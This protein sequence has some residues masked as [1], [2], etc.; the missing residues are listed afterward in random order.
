M[1]KRKAIIGIL[2][3][4]VV[5]SVTYAAIGSTVQVKVK[6]GQNCEIEERCADMMYVDCGAATDGPAYFLDGA[7]EVIGT[8]G[9]LCMMGNCSGAPEEWE[10]CVATEIK[11][12]NEPSPEGTKNDQYR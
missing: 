3:L 4:L 9:G 7:F 2:S 1:E 12:Q 8:S 10:R 11:Q 5:L 6:Y